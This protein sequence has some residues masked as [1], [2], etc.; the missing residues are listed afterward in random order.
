MTEFSEIN[1]SYSYEYND[2]ATNAFS[3]ID[4]IDCK[5]YPIRC[6]DCLNIA[7]LE[8][9]FNRRCFSTICGNNHKKEY[10]SFPSFIKGA[11]RNLDKFLCNQC[12]KSKDE[13]NL[14][15]CNNC[16]LVFCDNCKNN[17]NKKINHELFV[18][19]NKIDEYCAIHNEKNVY[20]NN[21]EKKNICQICYDNMIKKE[22]CIKIEDIIL[23]KSKI[24]QEYNK[25]I[26]NINNCKNVQ[27]LFNAW[28]DDLTKKVHNYCEA[29]NNYCLLQKSILHFLKNDHR[30]I[31]SKNFFVI[32]NYEAFNKNSNNIDLKIQQIKNKIY[33][34]Y[35][36]Y[37]DFEEVSNNFIKLLNNYNEINFVVDGEKVKDELFQ[38]NMELINKISKSDIKVK[39]KKEC[40][41]LGKSNKFKLS[42]DIKCFCS[43]NDE[44]NIIV[45]YKSGVIETFEFTEK[46]FIKPIIKIKEF[47]N[48]IKLICELD[49]NLFA[50]TDGKTNIKIIELDNKE[51]NVIQTLYL[52]EDSEMVY[53]MIYLPILSS[54]KNCHYFCTGDENHILIWKSNK[55]PKRI[56]TQDNAVIIESD[57]EEESEDTED[58]SSHEKT[59]NFTLV[60]DIKLGTPAR[61]LIEVN[62]NYIAVACTKKGCIKFYNVQNG[63]KEEHEKEKLSI[64]CGNN[65]LTFLPKKQKLIVGCKEGFSII[66]TNNFIKSDYFTKDMVTSLEWAT[67][68]YFICC[69]SNRKKRQIKKYS[70]ED[71]NSEPFQNDEKSLNK[72]EVWNFKIIRNKVFYA[73]ENNLKFIE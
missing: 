26:N 53:S 68:D 37:S 60:K 5:N 28:L 40:P 44:Q 59:L 47:E 66:D 15:K 72:N 62:G 42:W 56:N 10:S 12:Q 35:S 29:L 36:V 41:K 32:V 21:D 9:D 63:F 73:Y 7:L 20:F 8:V 71:S 34:S 43:L 39:I 51:Y 49:T 6:S 70:I 58:S 22:N 64:S 50:A 48:E 11:N 65:I 27:K 54:Y 4:K 33:N 31:Y 2:E 18:E 24:E 25:V 57:N 13:I 45:G 14:Q 46:E 69:C 61:C 52:K 3:E 38:R 19:I 16:D 1:N 55:K 17:H 67:K 23:N 30:D